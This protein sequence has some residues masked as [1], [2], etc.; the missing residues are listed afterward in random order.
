[1]NSEASKG[2]LLGWGGTPAVEASS[3]L[4]QWLL[5]AQALVRIP[6]ALSCPLGQPSPHQSFQGG[7]IPLYRWSSPFCR[8]RN[9]G[10]EVKLLLW[11]HSAGPEF[12]GSHSTYA[13]LSPHYLPPGGL[14]AWPRAPHGPSHCPGLQFPLPRVWAPATGT[15]VSVMLRMQNQCWHWW[16]CAGSLC[17]IATVLNTDV[18]GA[19]FLEKFL[20]SWT[21][22][23]ITGCSED[24][25]ALGRLFC[26][27]FSWYICIQGW[28]LIFLLRNSRF[29]CSR[30]FIVIVVLCYFR[31][32]YPC[33]SL[34]YFLGIF[35]S[36][37]FRGLE[38]RAPWPV[39]TG[40]GE[41]VSAQWDSWARG[42]PNQLIRE[43]PGETKLTTHASL[44]REQR[45]K[46]KDQK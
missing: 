5:S 42:C 4:G 15:S 37:N 26:Y 38:S 9:R 3:A 33:T 20:F 31:L 7:D 45:I 29:W 13:P 34:L 23:H 22:D 10:T 43:G 40:G 36:N 18:G 39:F 25:L 6:R 2:G 12:R 27:F 1:M 11:D 35:G 17:R 19:C 46:I 41:G 32:A 8:W 44:K 30:N 28:F 21:S 14:T 24:Q 16:T